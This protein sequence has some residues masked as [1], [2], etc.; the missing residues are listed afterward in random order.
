MGVEP[1]IISPPDLHV[2][3]NTLSRFGRV[4]QIRTG[5]SSVPNGVD[6]RFSYNTLYN[7]EIFAGF[8]TGYFRYFASTFYRANYALCW[9]FCLTQ[10]A[11]ACGATL[12]VVLPLFSSVDELLSV[13]ENK[14]PTLLLLGGFSVFVLK[15]YLHASEH[16]GT[17]LLRI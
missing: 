3:F 1:T 7:K 12:L 5:N 4:A 14:K 6:C 17:H 10:L 9:K 13:L 15:I 11:V 16:G 2:T 8:A